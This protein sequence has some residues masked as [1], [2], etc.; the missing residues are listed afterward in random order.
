MWRGIGQIYIAKLIK[1]IFENSIYK[2]LKMQIWKC[3]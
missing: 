3:V 1:E 2:K